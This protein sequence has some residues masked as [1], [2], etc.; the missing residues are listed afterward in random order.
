VSSPA[1]FR[2][3]CPISRAKK[4]CSTRTPGGVLRRPGLTGAL[5][6]RLSTSRRNSAAPHIVHVNIR[7]GRGQ[8]HPFAG[9]GVR[10]P[11]ISATARRTWPTRLPPAARRGPRSGS[12]EVALGGALGARGGLRGGDYAGLEQAGGETEWATESPAIRAA[13][14]SMLSTSAGKKFIAGKPMN[15][16]TNGSPVHSEVRAVCRPARSVRGSSPRCGLQASSLR[17]E[18]SHASP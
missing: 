15:P 17:F 3:K 2:L 14:S 4:S 12:Y 6:P 10:R 1:V 7:D 8:L 11:R 18:P 13:P 5:C 16:T 9:R